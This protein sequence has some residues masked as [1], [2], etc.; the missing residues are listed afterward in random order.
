MSEGKPWVTDLA[1]GLLPVIFVLALH[2]DVVKNDFALDAVP[3]VQTNP[4]V[5]NGNI[6]EIFRSSWWG[7]RGDRAHR[8]LYRPVALTWFALMHRLG[9]GPAPFNLGNL[10][11]HALV[12]AARFGL[13]LVLLRRMTH[14]RWIAL[15]AASLA[16]VHGIA[17]EAVVGMVGAAELLAALFVTCSWWSFSCGQ[18]GWGPMRGRLLLFLSAPLWL[19]AL[20]SKESAALF[21]VVLALQGC[22]LPWG[23]EDE[24]GGLVARFRRMGTW[25]LP[26]V[27]VLAVWLWMRISALGALF[28]FGGEGVYADFSTKDRL[29]SALAATGK[30]VLPAF[31]Y[32]FGLNPNVTH[33]DVPPPSGIF[34]GSVLLG[35][36]VWAAL[37]FWFVAALKKRSVTAL[38]A[39]YALASWL[40][41][42]NLIVGI[43][44]ITAFR[45]LYQ[46][47]FAVFA[48]AT[49]GAQGLLERRARVGRVLV[50]ALVI[51]GALG[52]AGAYRLVHEWRDARTLFEAAHE[53]NPNNLWVLQNLTSLK[54]LNTK[55]KPDIEA[56]E[57]DLSA[58]DEIAKT[59][60]HVPKTGEVDSGTAHLAFQLA[61]NRA[62][63]HGLKAQDAVSKG[64]EDPLLVRRAFD[65]FGVARATA[66]KAEVWAK[67]RPGDLF[68]ARAFA[69]RMRIAEISL[70]PRLPGATK[71][72]K[73]AALASLINDLAGLGSL[74]KEDITK[75]QRVE[76]HLLMAEAARLRSAK[77]EVRFHLEK[78]YALAP[79]NAEVAFSLAQ[80]AAR[81]GKYEDVL[82]L[83]RPALES[84]QAGPVLFELACRTALR[85]NKPSLAETYRRQGLRS[86][87]RSPT[88]REAQ[89]RLAALGG[90][91]R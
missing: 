64:M 28:D 40:P 57:R 73:D 70:L 60:P 17:T 23:G 72:D 32:P 52:A 16:G 41:T 91:K 46:P 26:Q 82:R 27:G 89:R 71:E 84:G 63:I 75:A 79:E 35:L 44:A 22:L 54:Y 31:F 15:G 21:P 8:A 39:A 50:A 45:F 14:R 65:E 80:E 20:L 55:E 10:L 25:M 9:D 58:L 5:E 87:A 33:Q 48:G 77:G 7:D 62:K 56:F 51:V 34:E 18:R 1:W 29:L 76:Y 13:L 78:A 68:E 81:Q 6:G 37:I 74:L 11:L 61:M 90:R 3:I 67:R 4:L 69:V 66:R 83:L 53:R 86:T 49:V 59:L 36:L 12:T 88:E 38:F 2:A 19:V 42:S 85:L 24:K 30:V 43:G 47:L